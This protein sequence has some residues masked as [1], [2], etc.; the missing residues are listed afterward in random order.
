[1][2]RQWQTV[3][4][5]MMAHVTAL[6]LLVAIPLL[7]MDGLPGIPSMTTY[8]PVEV[9]APAMPPA[10]QPLS[11]AT[12]PTTVSTGAPV[13][14]PNRI[15]PEMPAQPPALADVVGVGSA[16]VPGGV[17]T[18][19]A[20]AT[21]VAPPRA[22]EPEPVRPGGNVKAPTRTLFVAPDYP[23]TALA[24]RVS[25]SV[26]IEA[27]IDTDGHVRNARVLR[28][29]PLLDD[30]ALAAVRQ[31]RYTPTMLNG[32]PVPVVMTV[33]VRFDLGG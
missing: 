5:S 23:S 26:I 32:A 9:K 4:V 24:A 17:G 22:A 33:T 27:I 15:T 19:S 16:G 1:M 29:I 10:P 21:T 3:L 18:A 11:L 13:E 6:F 14:A 2:A 30:A 12:A 20:D 7:A 28:S 31:W 25:G 8:V